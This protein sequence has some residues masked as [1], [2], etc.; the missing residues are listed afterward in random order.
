MKNVFILSLFL[1]SLIGY[2]Q[3]QVF[4][5][6]KFKTEIVK[7]KL[8]AILPFNVKIT[9]KKLALRKLFYYNKHTK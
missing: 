5:S 4:E 2:S 1:F 9:Y 7:H 6:P 3:K 8:V